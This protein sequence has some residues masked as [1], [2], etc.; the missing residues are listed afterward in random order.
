MAKGRSW[1]GWVVAVVVLIVIAILVIPHFLNADTYR[2]K[3]EASLSKSLGRQV[4]LGHLDFS[5]FSGGLVATNAAIS[6]D[7]SFSNGPFLQAQS[8][9]IH[10]A[11][12]PL[13][14]SK[15]IEIKGF[16]VDSPRVVLLHGQNDKWNYSSLGSGSKSTGSSSGTETLTA[17]HIAIQNGSVSVGEVPSKGEPRV[18][19]QVNVTVDNFALDKSFPVTLSAHLPSDGTVNVDGAAGPINQQD[20]SLTPFQMH[21]VAQHVDPVAAGFLT[22]EDGLTG[23]LNVDVKASSDGHTL[24]V[25]NLTLNN[26]QLTIAQAADPTKKPPTAAPATASHSLYSSLTV[27]SLQLRDGH[28][29]LV[30]VPAQ[31]RPEVFDKVNASAQNFSFHS[32]FPFM[33]SAVLGGNGAFEANGTAGPVNQVDA[34]KTPLNAQVTL[35][36]IDPVAAGFLEPNQGIGGLV[37][38]G[39]RVTSNGQVLAANGQANVSRLQ[40]SKTGTPS[41]QPVSATFALTNDLNRFTGDIQRSQVNLGGAIFDVSGRY[42]QSG[43]NTLLNAK[44]VGNGVSID[45]LEAFLPALG[46]HLP[47]GSRLQGG[48]LTTNL[49]VTG[50]SK[51]PVISGPVR[52]QNTKLAGFNAGAKLQSISSV[53]GARTGDVT[54]IRSLSMNVREANGGIQTSN[55]SLDVPA[56]GTATGAGSVSPAGALDYNLV[57]KLVNGIPLMGGGATSQLASLIPGGSAAGTLTSSALKGGIPVHIGGTTSNPSFAPNLKGLAG[58]ALQ[59]GLQNGL[60]NGIPKKINPGDLLKGKTGNGNGNNPVSD[61]L[62][63]LFGGK[64]KH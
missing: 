44:I 28:L 35:K 22:P 50:S 12:L 14:L 55:I 39:V 30:K 11:V 51:D 17:G 45:R 46:V 19:N 2:P 31:G 32:Q 64:K 54:E 38:A 29:Q 24:H 61:A 10:V 5:L 43:V 63:G 15:K 1:I 34:S 37:N 20:A 42:Q 56:L 16:E 18:Y 40:L 48:T 27:D 62:G 36:N 52:V 49:D 25:A 57:V 21:L 3:I 26:P 41:A 8:L 4:T 23:L 53:L 59:G 7:P 6:D 60:Q 13:L 58:S 9:K 47:T 33:M